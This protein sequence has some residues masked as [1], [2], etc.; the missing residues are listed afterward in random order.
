VCVGGEGRT[1]KSILAESVTITSPV[2]SAVIAVSMIKRPAT[3][4]LP[5]SMKGECWCMCKEGDLERV[6]ASGR[7]WAFRRIDTFHKPQCRHVQ[8]NIRK[9]NTSLAE[10]STNHVTALIDLLL[11]IVIFHC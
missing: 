9:S 6:W 1:E 10:Q 4:T 2:D 8:Q 11:E 7:E 3:E 5:Y